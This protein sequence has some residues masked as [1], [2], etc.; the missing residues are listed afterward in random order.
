MKPALCLLI[1]MFNEAK[2]ADRCLKKVLPEMRKISVPWKVVVIDDGSTDR[3][4]QILDRWMKRHSKE[5]IALHH[6]TNQGYGAALAT[7]ISYGL[8]QGFSHGLCIDSDLTNDPKYIPVFAQFL[9]SSYDC[10]KA[11]RYIVGGGMKGVPWRRY[12][13]SWLGNQVAKRCFR[14]GI[15][16]CTN[17]FRML[18]L[19][20]VKNLTYTERGFGSILEELLYLKQTGAH[21]LEI[22]NT[23]TSR[24]DTESN[25]RYNLKTIWSY[26]K[27]ALRALST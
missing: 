24:V 25:F 14:M 19:E 3:T 21:C 12:W 26:A 23:L 15:H 9:E 13:A 22:P 11:S 7:G 6:E 5:V 8:K 4:P 17:G 27:Y 2:G 10:V 16:D 1:P 20:A 18:R